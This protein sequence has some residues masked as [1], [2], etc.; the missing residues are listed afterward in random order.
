[1]TENLASDKIS[2]QLPDIRPEKQPCQMQGQKTASDIR[3][4]FTTR[5]STE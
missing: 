3:Q 4:D 2:L 5:R 1:M